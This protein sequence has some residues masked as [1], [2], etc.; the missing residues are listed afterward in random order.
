[1]SGDLTHLL[2]SSSRLPTD[3]TFNLQSVTF[4]AHKAILATALPAF[5]DLFFGNEADPLL[6]E[7]DV[8]YVGPHAFRV[9]IHHVYGQTVELD[10]YSF[11]T[12]VELH[13]LAVNYQDDRFIT[14]LVSK[15]EEMVERQTNYETLT[16]WEDLVITYK[17]DKLQLILAYKRNT[18]KIEDNN[19]E[20]AMEVSGDKYIGFKVRSLVGWDI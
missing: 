18:V 15:M 16:W 17:V 13:W 6:Y 4:P 5:D 12:L 9:F 10:T 19:L 2:S 11:H 3:I 7:I 20:T 8:E 14:Q 1:M